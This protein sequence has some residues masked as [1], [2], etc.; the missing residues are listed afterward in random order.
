M[1]FNFGKPEILKINLVLF[2][3]KNIT[4]KGIMV[5]RCIKKKSGFSFLKFFL[6][7]TN[8]VNKIIRLN[9]LDLK[10]P[11]IGKKFPKSKLDKLK[12]FTLN[13]LN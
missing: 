4:I 12:T 6:S 2:E 7:G 5:I 1:K 9:I 3:E 13:L 11:V 8:F 10:T